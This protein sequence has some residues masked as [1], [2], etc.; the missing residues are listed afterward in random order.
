MVVITARALASAT[1]AALL[2]EG[3]KPDN[4]PGRRAS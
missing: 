2:L 3:K 1:S 4:R